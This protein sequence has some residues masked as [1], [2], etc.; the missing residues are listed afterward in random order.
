M[1][2]LLSLTGS[3][4]LAASPGLVVLRCIAS[5][6][7]DHAINAC[8]RAFHRKGQAFAAQ[9]ASR[10]FPST[11]S[12]KCQC[13]IG[14]ERNPRRMPRSRTIWKARGNPGEFVFPKVVYSR[15]MPGE[16][17]VLFS[18]QS[19]LQR[20]SVSYMRTWYVA[21][22]VYFGR[23]ALCASAHVRTHEVEGLLS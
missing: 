3:R 14:P 15:N 22:S 9:N 12:R 5:V 16:P 1:P 2:S 19:R 11:A 20:L 18:R 23:R 7:L 6:R 17:H 4:A 8:G 10:C 21:V 13:G